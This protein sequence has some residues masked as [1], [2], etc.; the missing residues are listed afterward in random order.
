MSSNAFVTSLL[1]RCSCRC[2]Y[3]WPLPWATLHCEWLLRYPRFASSPFDAGFGRLNGCSPR[4]TLPAPLF[5]PFSLGLVH[6]RILSRLGLQLTT[7]SRLGHLSVLYSLPSGCRIERRS[8]T[9]T[10]LAY[11]CSRSSYRTA[12]AGVLLYSTLAGYLDRI[13]FFFF[14]SQWRD[15]PLWGVEPMSSASWKSWLNHS[16]KS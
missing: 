12:E 14:I 1:F 3:T 6:P 8:Y 16:V 2:W 15:Y 7:F 5:F 11:L 13:A 4:L 9:E 10:R